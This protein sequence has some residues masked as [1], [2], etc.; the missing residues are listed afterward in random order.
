MN[1]TIDVFSS[2][3]DSDETKLRCIKV[4]TGESDGNL[5]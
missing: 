3:P 5:N 4:N 1:Q 2:L